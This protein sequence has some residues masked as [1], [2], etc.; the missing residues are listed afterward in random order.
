MKEVAEV[1]KLKSTN[2][3]LLSKA[4]E[5]NSYKTFG[6]IN[7]PVIREMNRCPDTGGVWT[8]EKGN[9]VWKPDRNKIPGYEGTNKN[10]KT[11]GEILDK[12]KIEGISFKNGVPDFSEVSKG[13]VKIDD[14]TT[15]RNSN[16]I[17]ADEKLAKERGCTPREVREWRKS[18]GYTWHEC[19]DCKTMQKVP[20]D[21]HGNIAHSGG[22]SKAK[23]EGV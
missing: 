5:I 19:E 1:E 2:S 4:K 11:W 18:N 16:F 6:D 7:S 8:G 10:G 12:N 23:S 17:Q 22:I 9:S 3:E 15:N 13:N 20:T 21:V 14:F